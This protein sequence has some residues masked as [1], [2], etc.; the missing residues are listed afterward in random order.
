MLDVWLRGQLDGGV[1]VLEGGAVEGGS[2]RCSGRWRDCEFNEEWPGI[3]TLSFRDKAL[4]LW[5][6][7]WQ[8]RVA[9]CRGALQLWEL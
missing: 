2:G 8:E 9:L 4:G 7:G 6:N 5:L 1:V 3:Y